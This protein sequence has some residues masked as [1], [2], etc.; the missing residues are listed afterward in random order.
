MSLKV[1]ISLLI[2]AIISAQDPSTGWLTYA[3]FKAD[4]NSTVTEVSTS[5]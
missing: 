3:V 5:W 1:T 4:S 2:L